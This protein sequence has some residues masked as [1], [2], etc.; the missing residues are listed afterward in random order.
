MLQ[1][2]VVCEAYTRNRLSQLKSIVYIEDKLDFQGWMKLKKNLEVKFLVSLY[3]IDFLKFHLSTLYFEN[4]SI[5]F[6]NN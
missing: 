3:A 1:S 4:K 6:P 5:N 2:K